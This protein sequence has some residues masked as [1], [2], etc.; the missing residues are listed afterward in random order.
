MIPM[1]EPKYIGFLQELKETILLSRYQAAKLV[2][3]E[4]ILLYFQTGKKLS[5]KIN[6]QKWGAKVIH[7]IFYNLQLELSGLRG[8]SVTK[9]MNMRHL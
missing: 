8:Y 3:R 2:N 1:L 7:D 4:L 9:I 5:E 6:A